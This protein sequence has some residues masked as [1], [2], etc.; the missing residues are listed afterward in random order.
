MLLK[1]SSSRQGNTLAELYV[2]DSFP[3]H[4]TTLSSQVDNYWYDKFYSSGKQTTPQVHYY[5]TDIRACRWK[6]ID[7][8]LILSDQLFASV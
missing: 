6:I 2:I 4:F 7:L 3:S 5:V 8:V 1:S